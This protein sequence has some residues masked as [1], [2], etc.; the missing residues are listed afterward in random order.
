MMINRLRV[1]FQSGPRLASEGMLSG[2]KV[3][4]K[5]QMEACMEVMR[6]KP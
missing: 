4:E 2:L 3:A 5:G 1:R 6:Q